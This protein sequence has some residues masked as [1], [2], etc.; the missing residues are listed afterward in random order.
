MSK[1]RSRE[2]IKWYL[3]LLL[4]YKI[5][6]FQKMQEAEDKLREKNNE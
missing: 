3:D 4:K 2:F 1:R 5:P 6:T